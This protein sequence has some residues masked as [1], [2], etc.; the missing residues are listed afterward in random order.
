M[1]L[2]IFQLFEAAN[3]VFAV[4]L[5]LLLAVVLI[6]ISTLWRP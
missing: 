4:W 5:P 2:V 1:Y 3:I 6:R